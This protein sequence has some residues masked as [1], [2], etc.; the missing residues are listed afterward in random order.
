MRGPRELSF[1][2]PWAVTYGA[3]LKLVRGAALGAF[4]GRFA[5]AGFVALAGGVD[6]GEVFGCTFAAPF[7]T[8][9]VVVG[10]DFSLILPVADLGYPKMWNHLHLQNLHH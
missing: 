9:G 5:F 1:H 3:D 4:D 8:V 7:G 6:A 2:R 10:H